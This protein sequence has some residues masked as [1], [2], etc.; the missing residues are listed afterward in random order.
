MLKVLVNEDGYSDLIYVGE[1]NLAINEVVLTLK[2]EVSEH[3][4]RES[5]QIGVNQHILDEFGQFTNHS[6]YPSCKVKGNQLVGI[7]E[8][9]NGDSITFDYNESEDELSTPFRCNCCNKLISGRN[10]SNFF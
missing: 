3:P 6:C 2:G 5:I 8:I 7:K 10:T 1:D 4:S 9:K